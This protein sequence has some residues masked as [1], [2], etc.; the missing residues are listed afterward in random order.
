MK[1]LQLK[2]LELGANEVLTRDQLKKVMGGGS[3]SE[4]EGDGAS[5]G[6]CFNIN[7]C[8]QYSAPVPWGA[9]LADLQMY[10]GLT[11]EGMCS[12]SAVCF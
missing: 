1:K 8:W 6:T 9:C 10:C 3:G 4:G 2:A 12:A 5:Y 11:G 7:G